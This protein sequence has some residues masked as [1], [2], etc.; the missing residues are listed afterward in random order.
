MNMKEQNKKKIVILEAYVQTG[1]ETY[2][3]V[4]KQIEIEVPDDGLD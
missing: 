2:T 1:Y 4:F 3:H